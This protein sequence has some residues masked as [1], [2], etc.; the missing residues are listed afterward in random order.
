MN[1]DTIVDDAYVHQ[2][3][4]ELKEAPLQALRGVSAKDARAL[5]AAFGIASIGELAELRIVQWA[6]AISVLAGVER[7]TPEQL[8][9]E[10]LLDEAV[11]MTFPASDPISVDSGVTHV[12]V[13]PDMVDAATD[14]QHAHEV[15]R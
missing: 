2:S 3:F 10:T 7:D 4:R 11:E 13:A 6:Q 14:H 12:E 1:I 8:A 15:A 5:G 9:K